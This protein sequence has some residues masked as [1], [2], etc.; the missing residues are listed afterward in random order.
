MRSNARSAVIMMTIFLASMM[1]PLL[2]DNEPVEAHADPPSSPAIQVEIFLAKIY[3]KQELDFEWDGVAEVVANY[4]ISQVGHPP[5][6]RERTAIVDFDMDSDNWDETQQAY[7]YDSHHP[8]PYTTQYYRDS[9]NELSDYPLRYSHA[10]CHAPSPIAIQITSAFENDASSTWE[11]MSTKGPAITL[12]TAGG[13]LGATGGTTGPFVIPTLIV[14]GA[15]FWV[16]AEIQSG[17][18]NEDLGMSPL[19]VYDLV[20]LGESEI[21]HAEAI[22]EIDYTYDGEVNEHGFGGF[23]GV[24]EARHKSIL[25]WAYEDMYTPTIGL[26][27]DVKVTVIEN[28]PDLDCGDYGGGFEELQDGE[29]EPIGSNVVPPES[30]REE[31]LANTDSVFWNESSNRGLR[32]ES[33]PYMVDQSDPVRTLNETFVYYYDYFSQLQSVPPICPLMI[34][35]D[36][37]EEPDD[38]TLNLSHAPSGVPCYE[39]TPT[40]SNSTDP[41]NDSVYRDPMEHYNLTGEIRRPMTCE[42]LEDYSRSFI[43]DIMVPAIDALLLE[44]ETTIPDFDRAT[45]HVTESPY[46]GDEPVT[47]EQML[48]HAD[49]LVNKGNY[50][51]A[52]NIDYRNIAMQVLDLVMNYE[53]EVELGTVT[54]EAFNRDAGELEEVTVTITEADCDDC[55]PVFEGEGNEIQV[56][57]PPGEYEM[58]MMDADGNLIETRTFETQSGTA[59]AMVIDISNASDVLNMAFYLQGLIIAMAPA[60]VGFAGSR[61][62]LERESESEESEKSATPLWVGVVIFLAVFF[63]MIG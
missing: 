58:R 41:C 29:V 13:V 21:D 52:I 20:P 1:S 47:Y 39:V 8:N 37:W 9:F 28:T 49:L 11:T 45:T 30:N 46:T 40:H 12:G 42:E 32:P 54:I 44:A 34:E 31:L 57:L 56:D 51:G 25:I 3:S 17:N 60:L 16:G 18:E 50:A 6:V 15:V 23:A 22:G 53:P 24:D 36:W 38:E 7:V 33:Y 62:Y 43:N 26:E 63:M 14:A 35:L 61:Q 59:N 19:K 48:G 2:I 5:Q 27:F 4:Q 55:E 10:E